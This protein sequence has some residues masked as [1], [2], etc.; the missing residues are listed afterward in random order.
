MVSI[1]PCHGTAEE[2]DRRRAPDMAAKVFVL[3]GAPRF[4]ETPTDLHEDARA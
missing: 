2:H 4:P 1:N 3:D